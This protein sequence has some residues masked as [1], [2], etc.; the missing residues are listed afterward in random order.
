MEIVHKWHRSEQGFH[1]NTDMKEDHRTNNSIDEYYFI[2][3][4]FR[5]FFL[6]SFFRFP[7]LR[8]YT[9][10]IIPAPTLLFY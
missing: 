4:T 9:Q 8:M 1:N 3:G 5:E 2:H 7:A 6:D 10:K